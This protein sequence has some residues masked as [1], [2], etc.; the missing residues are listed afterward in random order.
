MIL[1]DFRKDSKVA[2][3]QVHPEYPFDPPFH[4][5]EAYPEYAYG[6]L[7]KKKNFVYEGVRN[8]FYQLGLDSGNFNT[9]LW[10]PL[11]EIIKP[12]D[13]VLIKPNLVMH[14]N[15][16][17]YNTDSLITHGSVLRSITDYAF[18]AL[19]NEGKLIIGDAPLQSC[20]IQT[21]IQANRLDSVLEFYSK[22]GLKVTFQD[23]RMVMMQKRIRRNREIVAGAQTIFTHI[24]LREKSLHHGD[25]CYKKYRVTNYNPAFMN[26]Q[27]NLNDHIYIIANAVLDADVV[28]SVPKLKTHR[29]SGITVTMK[30]HVGINAHKDCLPHHTKGSVD[31]CGDE[32]LNKSILKNMLVALSEFEDRKNSPLVTKLVAVPK[33]AL[34]SL[35]I[36][37]SKD[38]Y[39]EGSWW[40]NRTIY[41]TLIDLNNILLFVENK[42]G[43]LEDIPARRFLSIVDGIVAGE[44]EG[45]L[46]PTPKDAGVLLAGKNPMA[47]DIVCSRIM[48]FDWGKIPF[49][50]KGQKFFCNFNVQEIECCSASEDYRGKLLYSDKTKKY[51]N[52]VPS[53]GWKGHIEI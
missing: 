32:Y 29:K 7:S 18:L 51:L 38:I 6:K 12:G 25:E 45:P 8:L 26:K 39:F 52:F 49:L 36:R 14:F 27:H 17:G 50:V 41:K 40:G 19:K 47:V 44:G 9:P 48:G 46:E 2:V 15:P 28:I 13:T 1:N 3:E 31:E 35:A 24:N 37:L 16:L 10:N 20:N 23:F 21:A 5:S 42:N 34:Y 33:R 11:G 22:A 43:Q 53:Q 30:N 4:P